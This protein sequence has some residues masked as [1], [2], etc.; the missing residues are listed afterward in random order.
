MGVLGVKIRLIHA[1]KT[2]ESQR[3][4]SEQ[5]FDV[6]NSSQMSPTNP[7]DTFLYDLNARIGQ[8]GVKKVNAILVDFRGFPPLS[9]F[10]PA[11]E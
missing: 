8:H 1:I 3:P 2:E 11:R 9:G 10:P 4:K 5:R 7:G 6:D